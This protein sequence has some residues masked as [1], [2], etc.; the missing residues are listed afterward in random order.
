DQAGVGR[1]RRARAIVRRL[2]ATVEHQ[3]YARKRGRPVHVHRE[4]PKDLLRNEMVASIPARKRFRMRRTRGVDVCRSSGTP[5]GLEKQASRV[6]AAWSAVR[7]FLDAKPPSKAAR[8][9][10]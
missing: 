3:Q 8:S 9:G 10:A 7:L 5:A 2:W 4:R 6:P 1:A